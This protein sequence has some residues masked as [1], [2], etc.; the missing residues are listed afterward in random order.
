MCLCTR[1][2][3]VWDC[4]LSPLSS[5]YFKVFYLIFCVVVLRLY[6]FQLVI[7]I[8]TFVIEAYK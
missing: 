6:V 7:N 1:H 5:Y 8:C 4:F 2:C 3:L